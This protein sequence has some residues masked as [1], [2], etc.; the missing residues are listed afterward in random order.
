MLTDSMKPILKNKFRFKN[1]YSILFAV[2]LLAPVLADEYEYVYQD[3]TEEIKEVYSQIVKKQ[4]ENEIVTTVS[5][6]SRSQVIFDD[7]GQTILFQK[8]DNG[9]KLILSAARKNGRIQIKADNF[10]KDIIVD[11]E[12]WIQT[13]LNT[14]R[15]I[16]SSEKSLK[17]FLISSDF[18]H[19]KLGTTKGPKIL[20]FVL[21]KKNVENIT[22]NGQTVKAWKMI[23]TFQDMRS[24]FWKSTIWYRMS[25]GL[26]LRY[27]EAR[28]APGTPL[29]VGELIDIKKINK[30]IP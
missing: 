2:I 20:N 3:K 30:E 19:E 27:E 24:L 17:F 12:A 16:Q 26:R 13:T 21:K 28:G 25:D 11:N 14:K 6:N 1:F 7:K 15:F 9:G 10:E 18:N 5:A 4:G 23:F 29:T 8:W 22:F